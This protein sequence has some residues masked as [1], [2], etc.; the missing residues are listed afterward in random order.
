MSKDNIRNIAIVA[1]VDHGKTTLVDGLLKQTQTFSDHQ[2]EMNQDLIMDSGDQE[3]ERGITITAKITAVKYQDHKIN[4]IDTPGHADFGGEVERTLNMADGCI[5]VVDSQ[6]GPMPQTKFVLKKAFA[7]GLKPIVVINKIDK[8]GADIDKVEDQVSDLF[9]ELATDEDQ[10]HFST[11]YA[12]GRDGKS[13]VTPPDDPDGEADFEPVFKAILSDIPAPKTDDGE[14]L[15]VLVTALDWDSF[16]GKYA[17]GR[18][19]RGAAR[20]NQEITIVDSK[21]QPRK[22]KIDKLF[23][24][25]GLNRTEVD[26]A[27]AGEIIAVTGISDVKISQTLTS[28]EHPD[29]LPEITLEPPTLSMYLGPNTSPLK[30]TEGKLTTSRQIGDRLQKELE[31]NIGLVVEPDGIGFTIKGRGEL[32]LSVLIET[33]RREGFELEVGS[34]KVVVIEKDGQ[35]MEPTEEITVEVPNEFSGAVQSEFGKRKAQLIEQ[36]PLDDTTTKLVYEMPTRALLGIRTILVTETKGTVVLNSLMSGYQP[37]GANLEQQRNGVLIAWENGTATPYS[38]QTAEARG[39]L[40]IPAGQKVYTGQIVG[41]NTRNDDMDINIVKEKHL[42]NMRASGSDGTVKLTPATILSLEQA[43]DFIEDDE[44]LEVTPSSLRL[45]KR[46]LNRS[47]R[48]KK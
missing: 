45:R 40:F 9:L 41:L 1:H 3:K 5:L 11:I 37:L 4:I 14:G 17:I 36:L 13:W 25:E 29:A 30:G 48:K 8:P 15:Q 31:T 26:T 44:L 2:N 46:E 43:I 18:I 24:H 7:A 16:L 23:I 10:L 38:L 33:M 27:E 19:Q 6:E 35:K 47:N 39:T 20:K 28:P 22:G 21:N 12:I 34:P 42:T 32:H